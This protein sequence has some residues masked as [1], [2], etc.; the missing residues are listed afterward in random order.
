M[1]LPLR[2]PSQSQLWMMVGLSGRA[3][4]QVAGRNPRWR[5]P[6]FALVFWFFIDSVRGCVS[7]WLILHV[8]CFTHDGSST[9]QTP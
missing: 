5:F 7:A 1:P 4:E 8:R 6:L 3:V 9:L 2:N